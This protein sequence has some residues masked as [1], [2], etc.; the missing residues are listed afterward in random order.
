MDTIDDP[1]FRG[2]QI[3]GNNELAADDAKLA[4]TFTA[5]PTGLDPV[6]AGGLPDH[7]D[8]EASV[9]RINVAQNKKTVTP[10]L[11]SLNL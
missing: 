3:I 8:F 5:E 1:E 7:T 6:I 10:I 4:C 11:T 2:F 9:G